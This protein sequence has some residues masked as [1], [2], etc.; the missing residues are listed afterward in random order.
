MIIRASRLPCFGSRRG[1]KV[2]CIKPAAPFPRHRRERN[3]PG[4]GPGESSLQRPCRFRSREKGEKRRGRLPHLSIRSIYPSRLKMGGEGGR[5]HPRF[6]VKRSYRRG[7]DAERDKRVKAER[8][9]LPGQHF[10][11]SS[12]RERR[13]EGTRRP[14]EANSTPMPPC[15]GRLGF[16]SDHAPFCGQRPAPS[17]I[18]PR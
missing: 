10:L 15:W 1:K 18:P 14:L 6:F 11:P 7:G 16:F 12:W 3:H 5:A 4:R 9:A 17:F 13:Q 8:S 2:F